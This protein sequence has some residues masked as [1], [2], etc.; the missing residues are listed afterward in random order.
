M[1]CGGVVE[2][3]GKDGGEGTGDGSEVEGGGHEEGSRG[4]SA[5]VRA[6]QGSIVTGF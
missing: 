4:G 2:D 5:E 3:G 1:G 6:E